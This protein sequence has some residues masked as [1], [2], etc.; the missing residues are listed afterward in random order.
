M[1][2]YILITIVAT[3]AI[4]SSQSNYKISGS[5]IDTESLPQI[6]ASVALHSRSDSSIVTGAVTKVGGKFSMS[7]NQ[8]EYYI[9]VTSVGM[10]TIGGT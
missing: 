5:I 6:G 9:R 8:G 10:D 4:L 1:L 2:K 3:T 7:A